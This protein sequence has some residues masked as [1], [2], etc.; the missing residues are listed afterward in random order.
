[1]AISNNYL[2]V[3]QLGN[4]VTAAYSA[5][6][7]IFAAAYI[8]VYLESVATGVQTLQVEGTNYSLTFDDSGFVVT[9]LPGFIPT[10][11]NYVV[12]GRSI[13]QDQT[14]PYKTSKGFDGS[15]IE[16]SYDKL[17]GMV[18]DLSNTVGRSLVFPLGDTTSTV[19]PPAAQRALQGLFFDAFGAPVVGQPSAATVS[20]AMQPVVAAATLGAARTA[21]GV[22][23]S[24]ANSDITSLSAM[25]VLSNTQLSKSAAYTVVNADKGKTI[26]LGGSAFYT[27]TLSAVGGYDANF[28]IR[29][30]NEDTGRC[31]RISPNAATSFLLWPGQ[32]CEIFIESATWKVSP[33]FQRWGATTT[34]IF[35][36]DKTN[37]LD[38]NDGLATGAGNALLTIQQA[39]NYIRNFVDCQNIAIPIIQ[40]KSGDVQTEQ[41]TAFGPLVDNVQFMIQGDNSSTPANWANYLWN[42]SAGNTAIQARDYGTVTVQ[43]VKFV[44]LGIGATA[45]SASQFGTIDFQW[46]DF[47]AFVSGTHMKA[48][49]L[50]AINAL[51]T[52]QVSGNLT[53]HA[54]AINGGCI[55]LGP[56]TVT[57]PNALTWP[58]DFLL[59]NGGQ[60]NLAPITFSGAGSGAGSTG[61]KYQ[62]A[63]NGVL[64]LSGN[65]IPG[66]TAGITATGGQV[67]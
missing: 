29:V 10:A 39:V 54:T 3:K 38:T 41:V 66:A 7:P 67:I 57:M 18:Q 43:G 23:A 16:G 62:V 30:V 24:G 61:R 40:L 6:W 44:A 51:G 47:G 52:Y 26:S 2:P 12:I 55:T 36:I 37:G 25:G 58:A 13:A 46:V 1:M 32:T 33:S 28:A 35:Y 4:G 48:F 15:K 34:P 20:A 59:C 56:T 45:L 14:N 8:R 22:A 63:A 5:S 11:A 65:T 19:L 50:G 49:Q 17:T 53:N 27:L 31:K 9:F 42:V 60:I 21:M 64:F